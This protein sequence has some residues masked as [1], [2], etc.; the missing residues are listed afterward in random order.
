M[1]DNKP[2]VLVVGPW[3]ESAGGV[4]TF[5]R[6]LI[7]HSS[8]SN[9]WTFRQYNISRTPHRVP[10]SVVF[11]HQTFSFLRSG[12][13]HFIKN[14]LT[15]AKNF[16]RFPFILDDVDV[17]QIQ[18]SD[19]YAFWEA[20][21]YLL[22]SKSKG[23]PVSMR[24]GGVFNVFYDNSKPK[25]KKLIENMLQRPDTIVVQS[26]KWK[27]FFSTL[28]PA[29][30]L[31]IMPNAVP[32]PPPIPKRKKRINK[33]RALFIC[34]SEAKRKGVETILAAAPKLRKKVI[35]VF[36]AAT[37]ELQDRVKAMGLDDCIELYGNIPRDEMKSIFYPESDLL[38]L[39]SHFEGFPNTMLE[40]MA[41]GL[42]LVTS[43]AG[44]IPEVLTQGVHAFIN[45][46][47]D[48]EALER[49]VRYLCNNPKKRHK[50]GQN[51][52]DLILE[53][54]VITTAFTRFD[55]IWKKAMGRF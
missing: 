46:P 25:T 13:R 10:K 31:H 16:G 24:F 30:R 51:C 21:I 40:A 33:V 38:L 9:E 42:P 50:M 28:T 8:L 4:V 2:V 37:E 20:C 43:P 35:F 53:K 5:Q 32:A 26:E 22:L 11:E 47:N 36:V 3:S 49:D 48:A 7:L 44:A 17:V 27:D 39:P 52:Y 6:N 1:G 55:Y 45:D 34:T 14:A 12:K 29:E 18:S 15:V 54:Y 19:H 41:A 23:K